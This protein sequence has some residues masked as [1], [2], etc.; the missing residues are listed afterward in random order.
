MGGGGS[1]KREGRGNRTTCCPLEGIVQ[2][3]HIATLVLHI[4]RK[5]P[6]GIPGKGIGKN[7]VKTT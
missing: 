6:K 4:A 2:K 3:R 1:H 5:G 7:T